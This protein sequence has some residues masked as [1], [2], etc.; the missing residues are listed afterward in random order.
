MTYP[1]LLSTLV[2][3][4]VIWFAPVRAHP[5]DPQEI[6]RD[7][8]E[9]LARYVDLHHAVAQLVGTGSRDHDAT[10]AAAL[11]QARTHARRGDIFTAEIAAPI[12]ARLEAA[13]R[14]SG[15]DAGQLQ[16]LAILSGEEEEDF[17]RLEVND[18]LPGRSRGPVLQGGSTGP[19]FQMARMLWSLPPLPRELEY[20]FIGTSL[21]LVDTRA[22]LVVDLIENVLPMS[23]ETSTPAVRTPC[24]VHPDLPACWI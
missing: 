10:F 13:V 18:L 12:R 14:S 21:A 1:S 8:S 23:E 6:P 20:R 22:N 11:R 2:V 5:A 19:A 17:D 3:G 16:R 4:L 9:R 15:F 24:E 7:F